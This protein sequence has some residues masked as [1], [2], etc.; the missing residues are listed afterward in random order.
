MQRLLILV[1]SVDTQPKRC[2]PKNRISV[3]KWAAQRETRQGVT[4]TSLRFPEPC[5]LRAAWIHSGGHMTE[6]F[7]FLAKN[8]PKKRHPVG[9]SPSFHSYF[10]FFFVQK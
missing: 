3:Q 9:D 5:A 6:S 2:M 7:F 4:V 10:G 1:N 8:P